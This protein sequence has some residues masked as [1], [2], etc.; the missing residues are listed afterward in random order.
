MLVVVPP[1]RAGRG[2]LRQGRAES[3]GLSLSGTKLSLF[4]CL[5]ITHLPYVNLCC[6][7]GSRNISVRQE[8]TS[9]CFYV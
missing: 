3:S 2:K 9:P 4:V 8:L 1:L 5:V 7:R 6:T